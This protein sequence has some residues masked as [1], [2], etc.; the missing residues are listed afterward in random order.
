[1]T[2]NTPLIQEVYKDY[3]P[4]VNVMKTVE[5]LLGYVPPKDLGHLQSIVLTNTGALSRGRKRERSSSGAFISQVLGRYHHG[6]KGQPAYIEIYVDNILDSASWY[7]LRLPMLRNWMLAKV[8]Y[9]EIGHHIQA[10]S[11][12]K[13]VKG[14][15][16][17]EKYAARLRKRFSQERYGYFRPLWKSFFWFIKKIGL[18]KYIEHHGGLKIE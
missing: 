2:Q 1:M 15:A 9:H 17:A 6:W 3:S 4:P 5:V 11:N 10:I 16:F 8:L 7:D 18:V 12:S 14:E 13:L